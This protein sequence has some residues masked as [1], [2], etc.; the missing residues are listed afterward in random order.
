MA[1]TI[2]ARHR[3]SPSQGHELTFR[4][5]RIKRSTSGLPDDYIDDLGASLASEGDAW[6]AGTDEKEP[7][8]LSRKKQI[9]DEQGAG[10]TDG[11]F[12]LDPETI[13]KQMWDSFCMLLLVYCSFA[14][15]YT[16]A[17]SSTDSS[18]GLTAIDYSD[19]AIDLIFMIDIS[20]TFVTQF[21]NQGVMEKRISVIARHYVALW[22][23]PDLAGSF[24]FDLVIGAC[25]GSGGNLGGM[26]LVRMIRSQTLFL[27]I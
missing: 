10:S 20:L 26:K 24:P 4:S 22:F 16:M 17:F 11:W 25:L 8:E 14:V 23:F 21:D 27:I 3:L 1:A 6:D 18:G 19:L 7:I 12:P 9:C 2:I 15:P 5:Q 13:P